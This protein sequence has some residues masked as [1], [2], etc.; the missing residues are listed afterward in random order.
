LAFTDLDRAV[1]LLTKRLEW[2]FSMWDRK[3]V[4]DFYKGAWSC[5]EM[6][7]KRSKTAQLALPREFPLYREEGVYDLNELADW[8]HTGA[9]EIGSLFDT[10]NSSDYF[11]RNL[12]AAEWLLLQHS[13]K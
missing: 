12:E 2:T 7:S 13:Q 6:M 4:Y 8:F 3:L 9:A 1:G 5:C 10:R 11:A